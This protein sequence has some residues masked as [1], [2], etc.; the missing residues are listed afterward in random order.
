VPDVPAAAAELEAK[1]LSL[2]HAARTEPWGQEIARLL[3][4]DGLLIGVSSFP[5]HEG[6]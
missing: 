2:V 6:G 1:G 4:P 5:G 3:S